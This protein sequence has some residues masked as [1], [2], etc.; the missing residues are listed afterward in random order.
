M[1]A[2]CIDLCDL[3]GKYDVITA[4]FDMVNYLDAK[5]LQ[6]FLGCMADHLNEGGY[7][8]FDINTLYGFENVA[9]GAFIVDDEARFLAI[10]SDF[11]RGATGWNLPSL[12]KKRILL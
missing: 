2:E 7:F 1:D 11:G 3:E 8:V 4:V 10:D 6:R 9:V 12:K 5:A